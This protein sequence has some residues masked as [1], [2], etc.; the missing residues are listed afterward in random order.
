MGKSALFKGKN[1]DL[2]YTSA[3]LL[4]PITVT[5]TTIDVNPTS[6]QIKTAYQNCYNPLQVNPF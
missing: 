3:F 4:D 6:D 1:S 5:Y 2:N